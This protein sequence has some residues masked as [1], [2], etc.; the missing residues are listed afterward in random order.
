[1]GLLV[2]LV[3][4]RRTGNMGGPDYDL[5]LVVRADYQLTTNAASLFTDRRF[6]GEATCGSQ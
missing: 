1:M 5:H 6:L 3:A 2:S 4:R